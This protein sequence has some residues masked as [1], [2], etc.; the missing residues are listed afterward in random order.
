[1][2]HM[3]SV[4]SVAISSDGRLLAS[5]GFGMIKLWDLTTGELRQ[6]LNGGHT[7]LN[8]FISISLDNR[9]LASF[10]YV[11]GN[12]N[13]KTTIK[14]WDLTIG[15]ECLILEDHPDRAWTKENV[16]ISRRNG[17]WVL[18]RDDEIVLWLPPE[19]RIEQPGSFAVRADADGNTTLALGCVS[20]RV[21][22]LSLSNAASR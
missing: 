5:G 11:S 3:E 8:S 13:P 10:S 18:V 17:Q 16:S 22:I 6:T 1:M 15:K 19:Y 2:G 4:C 12:Y 20:G 21:I 14:L 7:D 9:V